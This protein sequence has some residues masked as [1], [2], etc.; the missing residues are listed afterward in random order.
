MWI[1]AALEKCERVRVRL[2]VAVTQ[3][4]ARSEKQEAVTVAAAPGRGI[5]A[6]TSRPRSSSSA[7]R[8][9]LSRS[10]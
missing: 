2:F 5:V 4:H 8:A 10:V 7:K 3:T 9:A 1:G 6:L